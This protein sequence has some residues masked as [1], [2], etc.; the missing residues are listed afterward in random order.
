ME[1]TPFRHSGEGRERI[2]AFMR[3]YPD[4]FV[5]VEEAASAVAGYL[6][7]RSR[8][9]DINGLAKNL[10][11]GFDGRYRWHWDPALISDDRQVNDK[12]DTKR[13]ERAALAIDAPILLVR[14][15]MSDVVSKAGAQAFLET[16]PS[17]EYVDVQE[18]GHMIAGDRND[19]FTAAVISFLKRKLS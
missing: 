15:R 3:S 2:L 19:A 11:L 7:H 17:A 1:N 8:P 14:G 9:D 13:Y 6:P 4:G 10:R 18:A 12:F 16:V 5:S